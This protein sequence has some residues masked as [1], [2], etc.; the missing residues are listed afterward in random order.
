MSLSLSA[1]AWLSTACY[2]LDGF[3]ECCSPAHLPLGY[4]SADPY[5]PV[6]SGLPDGKSR[7]QIIAEDSGINLLLM[8]EFLIKAGVQTPVA[9]FC[10]GKAFGLQRD[11]SGLERRVVGSAGC[12]IHQTFSEAKFRGSQ[13]FF[14]SVQFHQQAF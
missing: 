3:D 7:G 6:V 13:R 12:G 11:L 10:T 14:S 4:F 1:L 5:L 2:L 8:D 9:P